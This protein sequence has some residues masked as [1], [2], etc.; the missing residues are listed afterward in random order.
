MNFKMLPIKGIQKTSLIDYPPYTSCVIFIGGCNFRCGYC[1]NFNLVLKY[2]EIKTIDEK[3]IIDY[4]I[5]KKKWIDAVVITGG[6]PTLYP[7]LIDFFREIKKLNLKIKLDTNGSNP[8]LLWDMLDEK[9]ID[10]IAMD[11][12]GPMNSY[13]KITITTVDIEKIKKSI[14]L[15][16]NSNID[17]EFRTTVIPKLLTKED[18]ITISKELKGAKRY[19]MQQFCNKGSVLDLSFMNEKIY[20]KKELEEIEELIR[21]NFDEIIIRG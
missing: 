15:I 9:L 12:K 1:H 13:E 7:E 14:S 16:K 20:T 8:K 19:V 21:P 3:E 18:L 10:Y 5:S 2:K 6:E 17:Y 4:L 11:I